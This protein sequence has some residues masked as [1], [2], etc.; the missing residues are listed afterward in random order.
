MLKANGQAVRTEE[1]VREQA[2]MVFEVSEDSLPAEHP[3]RLI[4]DA[5]GKL[6][7]SQ[8][9]ANAK[10]YRGHAGRSRLS[11]RMLLTIWLYGISEGIGSA[12][13][14]EKRLHSDVAFRWIRGDV[15]VGRTTLSDFRSKQGEAFDRLMTQ[16]LG[17]LISEGLL[18]LKIVAQDGMRVRASAGTSSFRGKSSLEDCLEQARLHVKAVLASAD[19]PTLSE[20]M[21]RAREAAALDYQQRIERAMQVV[22]E[23]DRERRESPKR[24]RYSAKPGRAKNAARASTTDPDARVMKMPDGGF[25][26]GYNVQLATAGSPMGGPRTIVGVRVTNAGSDM[27]AIEPMLEQIEQR[28]GMQPEVLLADA[29]HGDHDSIRAAAE[30]GVTAVVPAPKEQPKGKW[31]DRTPAV[32]EWYERMETPEAKE[33]LRARPSIAELPNAQLRTRLGLGQIL[34][35]TLNKAWTVALLTAFA[36]NILT[37]AAKLVS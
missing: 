37:H 28:T 7:L 11:P 13:E 33:L 5:L 29:N 36:H 24:S 30:R 9:L 35:R 8:L 10:S 19:D 21:K 25:R 32:L 18:S 27:S 17:I 22:R 12:R 20:R 4:W 16:L 23:I 6:D 1:P 26:P 15:E 31:A 2:R 14:I 34:V 3:A